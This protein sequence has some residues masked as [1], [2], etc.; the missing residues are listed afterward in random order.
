M[1]AI[2]ER[3]RKYGVPVRVSRHPELNSYI[4]DVVRSACG[5]WK[6]GVVDKLV[7]AIQDTRHQIQERFVFETRLNVACGL[8][9]DI[10]INLSDA[11][12]NF[13]LK[14]GTLDGVES[15]NPKGCTFAIYL[16]TTEYNS[17]CDVVWMPS[18][19]S[20]EMSQPSS[21]IPIKSMKTQP[22][23]LQLWIE[24]PAPQS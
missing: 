13:L 7:L 15:P 23:T 20:I 21:I 16:Y 1:I 4:T 5:L 11:F 2:F 12:K 19:Y 14:I 10:V 24:R 9:Q 3:V 18:D 6:R 17:S 22:I 8:D